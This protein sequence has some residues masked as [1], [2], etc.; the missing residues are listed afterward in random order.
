MPCHKIEVTEYECA[1]CG[2]K[3]INR[4]NGKDGPRPTRCAKCKNWDW[5]EGRMTS[6]EKHLRGNLRRIL[7]RMYPENYH[8]PY[9]VSPDDTTRESKILV[10]RFLNWTSPRPTIEELQKIIDP[11][12]NYVKE[13]GLQEATDKKTGEKKYRLKKGDRRYKEI[14][15]VKIKIKELKKQKRTE[16]MQQVIDSRGK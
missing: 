15:N 1:K 5:E 12:I 6:I 10:W 4:I 11:P 2:Y 8:Q 13:L 16:L 7:R 9:S 14:T 3:W